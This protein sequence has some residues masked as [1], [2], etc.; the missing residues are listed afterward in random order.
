MHRSRTAGASQRDVRRD[1]PTPS[2]LANAV[3][4][5]PRP[6]GGTAH[7]TRR[8]HAN[9]KPSARHHRIGRGLSQVPTLLQVSD[10]SASRT[11][12]TLLGCAL[13]L[14]A[15][16]PAPAPAQTADRIWG[17]VHTSEGRA[18]TG[19]VRWDRARTSWG[20]VL[21]GAQGSSRGELLRLAPGPRPG[22]R[23]PGP[24]SSAATA[25]P[26]TRSIPTFPWKS[27]P[28]CVSVIWIRWSCSK[29]ERAELTLR[30]GRRLDLVPRGGYGGRVSPRVVVEVPGEE[31]VELEWD[32]LERVVFSAPPPTALPRAQPAVGH[33]RGPRRQPVHGPPGVGPGRDPGVR[34]A[35][36][37]GEGTRPRRAADPLRPH[38]LAHAH[39]P[40][41]PR[42]AER[43]LQP[44][45][46]GPQR[47]RPQQPRT[48]DRGPRARGGRR[49]VGA[50]A[51]GALPRSRSD[52][53]GAR[54]IQW[55]APDRRNGGHAR[56]GGAPGR[57]ALGRG[58][59]GQLG[60]V[61]RGGGMG[62]STRS[63]SDSSTAS[64]RTGRT[65]RG[66]PSSTDA[67]SRLTG[68]RDVG[69]ENKGVMVATT[70]TSRGTGRRSGVAAGP[71][72]RPSGGALRARAGGLRPPGDPVRGAGGARRG[73]GA[74]ASL[75]LALLCLLAAHPYPVRA[76]QAQDPPQLAEDAFV[77]PD[78]RAL[79][80]AAQANWRS[81]E[82][83]VLRYQAVIRQRI[84]AGR[85]GLRSRT[86]SSIGMRPQCARSGTTSTTPSCRCWARG[87][88]TP[89]SRRRGARASW[90]GST[91]SP[92]TNPSTPAE[93]ACSSAAPASNS[94]P[95]TPSN[96]P[97]P[98][99]PT[100]ATGTRAATR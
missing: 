61:G 63:N 89:A 41:H 22:A 77:D 17:R 69:P 12:G 75:A 76:A 20:D 11:A 85:S 54:R 24:S 30:S 97:W 46:R 31:E 84:S 44:G 2:A 38:P 14:S 29:G 53:G 71:V 81:V 25:S 49:A 51:D 67:P 66:S 59:G 62:S 70:E 52:V 96:T 39:G 34:R 78:A 33:G 95:A 57:A 10:A 56:G 35:R 37:P 1:A 18:H 7:P 80:R 45:A 47:C 3:I 99:A 92:S 90:T 50:P 23:R 72:E 65:G 42:G 19:F 60:G 100:G 73:R 86:V 13:V 74:R 21:S 36:R 93:T 48:A 16:L 9:G 40:R 94:D 87:P 79:F 91:I 83:S 8:V 26:G 5:R 98:R 15:S 4:K 6:W 27:A 82:Q 55:R 58:R 32:E 68:S 64:C 28:A 88:S 43:R